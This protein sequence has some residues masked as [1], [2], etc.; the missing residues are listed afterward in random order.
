VDWRLF[1]WYDLRAQYDMNPDINIYA[2]CL[3]ANMSVPSV[4]VILVYAP[5]R[6][7]YEVHMVDQPLDNSL[8]H[9]D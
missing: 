9:Q 1:I 4:D 8:S 7:A 2:C 3:Q 6:Q 5:S